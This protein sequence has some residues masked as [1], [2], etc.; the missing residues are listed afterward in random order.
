M[1]ETD[2]LRQ[3]LRLHDAHRDTHEGQDGTD[4]EIDVARDDDED[5]ARRHDADFGGLDREVPQ[6]ARREEN[7]PRQ[8]VEPDPD[9][10]E[11]ADHAKQARVEFGCCE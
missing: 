1:A 9:D 6:I 11:R 7:P 10:H 4:G 3:D 8:Q 5:H 2:I